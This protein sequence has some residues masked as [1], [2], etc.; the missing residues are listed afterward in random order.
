MWLSEL[1]SQSDI[2][3]TTLFY[4]YFLFFIF[5]FPWTDLKGYEPQVD[6]WRLFCVTVF[7]LTEED[8][9][10]LTSL[11][12]FVHLKVADHFI[13]LMVHKSLNIILVQESQIKCSHMPI[14][15]YIFFI[16]FT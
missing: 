7:S 12:L 10:M 16:F 14:L 11:V 4:F 15:T 13:I 1:G 9:F 2:P 5:F 6:G 3:Q 8:R